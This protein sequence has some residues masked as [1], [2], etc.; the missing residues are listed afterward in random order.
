MFFVIFLCSTSYPDAISL[1]TSLLQASHTN[2]LLTSTQK[3]LK[4]TLPLGSY[5]LKPVQRILKYH[6]LLDV[7]RNEAKFK[8]QNLTKLSP[9]SLKKHCDIPDVQKAHEMMRDVAYNIDQVKKKL[10][11]KNRVKELSGILDGWLGPD[12]TVLGELRQEGLLMEHN[13]PRIVFLFETMLII[14]KPK[15]DKRLQFKTYIP[16]SFKISRN[17]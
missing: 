6:L 10:E 8:N 5:L 11:Q 16:V 9:Q 2:S 3:M 15:E 12:L 14:T 7:S 4:H 13:K 1:L 17:L